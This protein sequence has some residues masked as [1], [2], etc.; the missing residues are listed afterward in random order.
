MKNKNTFENFIQKK[1]QTVDSLSEISRNKKINNKKIVLCHGTFDLLHAGHFRHFQDSKNLGDV[2]V[3]TVTSD[4]FINKGPGRPLFNQYL[5]AE[6]IASLSY[7]DYVG[8]VDDPSAIPSIKKIKPD[9]YVKGI[10]YKDKKSD[11]T[12]KIIEEEKEVIKNGGVLKFTDNITFSSSS[13]I[14]ENIFSYEKKLSKIL[15]NYKSLGFTYITSLIEKIKNL[16]VMLIGDSILDEYIYTDT[17]GK[18]AKESILATLK[19]NE[20]IFAGG[21]IAAA[22]NISDFCRS[23]FLITTLGSTNKKNEDFVKS[24]LSSNVKLCSTKLKNRPI[25]KKTRFVDSSYMRKMFEV[26]DM[27]DSPID[28]NE[29]KKI[30][31]AIKKNLPFVDLI[32]I[33]DFGHGLLNNKI[34]E[35]IY[36]SKTFLAINAQT[37]SANRG[38][39]LITKYKSADYICIDEPEFRLAMHDKNTSIKKLLLNSNNLP[40]AKV[41]IVTTGKNGCLIKTK[42]KILEIPAFTN[43]VVDTIGAG[44][45]FF[46]ISS[47][48]AYLNSNPMDIGFIGNVSGALKV[49]ILG[50]S[51]SIKKSN[52]LK[53]IES[54]IK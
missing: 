8:V 9:I 37:N 4:K 47:L 54:V 10:D 6:M 12:K 42:E 35:E 27:D 7:V 50:H 32:I 45:A 39:N 53:F 3:V 51:S 5:R 15:E 16:R 36:K 19:K 29:E 2:L 18:S 28:K 30:I 40:K 24:Q 14:N 17:L 13:L 22:N 21:S 34:I 1:I 44:D 25:T 38:Y 11:F 49:N 41:F 52:F 46:V 26:Y 48:F 20:E 33:T 43:T 23:V 31:S